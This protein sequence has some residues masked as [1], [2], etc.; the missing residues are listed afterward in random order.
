MTSNASTTLSSNCA[1][2]W[3]WC[4]TAITP[5]GTRRRR[6]RWGPASRPGKRKCS[7]CS[8]TTNAATAPGA[9]RSSYGKKASGWGVR[10]C[11]RACA[12][13][14]SGR[15]SPKPS[16]RAPPIRPT[17]G[18]ARRTCCATPKPGSRTAGAANA[19]TTRK[20]LVPPQNRGARSPR[21]ARIR[22]LSRC[23]CQRRRL[24]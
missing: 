24:F 12:G 7:P 18:G 19:T 23:R 13:M 16:P 6:G 11:A 17:A 8:T 5:S 10:S 15:S 14:G 20:P 21:L 2:C 3:T 4:P 22:R 1:R 9:S